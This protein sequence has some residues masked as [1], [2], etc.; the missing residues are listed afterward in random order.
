MTKYTSN[1]RTVGGTPSNQSSKDSPVIGGSG[2]GYR[3]YSGIVKEYISSVDEYMTRSVSVNNK[4]Y[5]LEELVES[6]SKKEELGNQ[7][8]NITLNPWEYGIMPD[9]SIIVY[10]TDKGLSVNGQLPVI[11]Y[12]FFPS[13]FSLPA[14]PGE[15]IWLIKEYAFGRDVYYWL[16]RKTGAKYTED[17]NYTWLE[18]LEAINEELVPPIN[19]SGKKGSLISSDTTPVRDLND[20]SNMINSNLPLG[21]SNGRI[22]A[23]SLA[24]TEEFTS[25]PVPPV[26]KKC[27]DTLIQGSNNNLVHLTT[28]KFLKNKDTSL[29]FTGNLAENTALGNNV[30]QTGR[31]PLSPAIDI[32]VGRK[33][34]ELTGLAAAQ[35]DT[36]ALN[37]V[38]IVKNKRQPGLTGLESYEIDKLKELSEVNQ[39]FNSTLAVDIDA[40]NCGA[41]LYLSNNCAIDET[42]GSSFNDLDTLGGS[43]LA[44]YADH[45]RVIADNS[46]RL[47]NRIG[48]SFINMD[49]EGNVV[50]KATKGGAYIS[51]KADG[52]IAIV[53]G[54]NGLIYLGGDEGDALNAA[55]V[56]T[57]IPSG[58]TVTGIPITSTMG[59][60]VGTDPQDASGLTGKFASKLLIK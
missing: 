7:L 37:D 48:Q 21:Y 59:G 45:N 36:E 52:S 49:S 40:T 27:G 55:L 19:S 31:T 46:L 57:G 22:A 6:Y 12:P 53:P 23:E 2:E 47:A 1:S 38:V 32:C 3:Y 35:K 60:V 17:A 20:F 54:T 8:A 10:V 24:F 26:K 4:I 15:H 28:E 44:T 51:L 56:Q 11:C 50:I 58:G 13:H 5:T 34:E 42:F 29:N 9:N 14:K 25:E 41:R 33:K 43:S 18:R 16:C 30:F 39:G